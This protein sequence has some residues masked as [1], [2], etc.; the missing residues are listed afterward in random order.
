[1]SSRRVLCASFF[2]LPFPVA[3]TIARTLHPSPPA[4]DRAQARWDEANHRPR[5]PPVTR[6]VA[7]RPAGQGKKPAGQRACGALQAPLRTLLLRGSLSKCGARSPPAGEHAGHAPA[8]GG[9]R[10][11]PAWLRETSDDEGL[12]TDRQVPTCGQKRGRHTAHRCPRACRVGRFR[13]HR[14]AAPN[15]RPP[16]DLLAWSTRHIRRRS[17]ASRVVDPLTPPALGF[18][19]ARGTRRSGLGESVTT[20][21]ITCSSSRTWP[22][23]WYSEHGARGM[24]CCVPVLGGG[25]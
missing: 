25:V 11:V 17:A 23:Q 3:K 20:C 15:G 19:A 1:M 24:R 4:G 18:N 13:A 12:P 21:S 14:A 2:C 7:Q 22:G 6:G 10:P 16:P 5:S 9:V 8:A